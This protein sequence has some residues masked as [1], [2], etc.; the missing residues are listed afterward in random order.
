MSATRSGQRRFSRGRLD[1]FPIVGGR[2]GPDRRRSRP[3]SI[4]LLPHMNDSLATAAP[5]AWLRL[6]AFAAAG[7]SV[8]TSVRPEVAVSPAR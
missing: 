8:L 5:G 3:S 1:V 7:A 4:R 6:A 2:P